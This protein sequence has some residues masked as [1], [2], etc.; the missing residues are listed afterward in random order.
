MT[1][2]VISMHL[3]SVRYNVST[4]G[5]GKIVKY[6][7]EDVKG[8]AQIGTYVSVTECIITSVYVGLF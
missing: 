4:V 8:V 1:P 6:V 3:H 7:L 5:Q 2:P